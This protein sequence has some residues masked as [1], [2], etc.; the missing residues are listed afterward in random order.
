[1]Q[2]RALK[3]EHQNE[4]SMFSYLDPD[5]V[6]CVST[7][8][9]VRR[10]EVLGYG[11]TAKDILEHMGDANARFLTFEAFVHGWTNLM[12]SSHFKARP[13]LVARRP[14]SLFVAG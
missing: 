4:W 14:A 1:M 5:S 10:M 12:S 8:E 13:C 9:F 6:G 2:E 3:L 7:Q 11:R